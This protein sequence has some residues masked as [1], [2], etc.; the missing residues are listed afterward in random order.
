MAVIKNMTGRAPTYHVEQL[1]PQELLTT[2]ERERK[3]IPTSPFR[4]RL[5]KAKEIE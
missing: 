2:S 1:L 5:H 4:S 3:A